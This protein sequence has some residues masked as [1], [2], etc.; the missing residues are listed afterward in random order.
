MTHP[1][2][3]TI[4]LTGTE[5]KTFS[6]SVASA[7]LDVVTV[8]VAKQGEMAQVFKMDKKAWRELSHLVDIAVSQVAGPTYP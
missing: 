3:R 5:G 1:S 7:P 8:T 4:T 2:S 6:V